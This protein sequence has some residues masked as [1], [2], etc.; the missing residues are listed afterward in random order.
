MGDSNL[1]EHYVDLANTGRIP[2]RKVNNRASIELSCPSLCESQ[3][4]L[5]QK[6]TGGL[7][8]WGPCVFKHLS[9]EAVRN[10]TTD[11]AQNYDHA[12]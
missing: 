4:G 11:L 1:Q 9:Q 3:P 2:R 5:G 7:R 12:I 6:V 8:V 10:M